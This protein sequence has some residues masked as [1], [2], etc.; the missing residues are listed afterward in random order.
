MD[1]RRQDG[2]TGVTEKSRTAYGRRKSGTW[3]VVA[4]LH[5]N[6]LCHIL[7]LWVVP[8]DDLDGRQHARIS[9]LALMDVVGY[10]PT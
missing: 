10:L 7:I 3:L 1:V 8:F 9:V 2:R 5:D 6:Q 4:E